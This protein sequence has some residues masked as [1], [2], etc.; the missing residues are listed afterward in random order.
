MYDLMTLIEDGLVRV[1]TSLFPV[2]VAVDSFGASGCRAMLIAI[3]GEPGEWVF[4]AWRSNPSGGTPLVQVLERVASVDQFSNRRIQVTL[5]DGSVAVA[6]PSSGC[7][8]CA[9]PLRTY[10]PFGAGVPLASLPS[11]KVGK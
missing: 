8:G 10:N 3:P 5:T 11:P 4:G 1:G 9:A 6:T 7:G 2:D